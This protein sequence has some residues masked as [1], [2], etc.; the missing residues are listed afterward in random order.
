M[1][2]LFNF[3]GKKD[4]VK[5]EGYE[6]FKGVGFIALGK[7]SLLVSKEQL[8]DYIEKIFELIDIEIK[9]PAQIIQKDIYYKP[10]KTTDVL[11]CIRDLA[12][13]YGHIFESR[14]SLKQLSVNGFVQ[15]QQ[16]SLAPPPQGQCGGS[17]LMYDF[18]CSLFYF[19]FKK[20]LIEALKELTKISNGQY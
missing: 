4:N 5:K 19:G 6:N 18:I 11:L 1:T 14:Y 12:K 13:N 8:A 3:M 16:Q 2:S 15:A 9:K 17:L 20:P 10:V 7:I